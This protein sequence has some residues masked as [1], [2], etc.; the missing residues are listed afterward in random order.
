MQSYNKKKKKHRAK[1]LQRKEKGKRVDSGY[2]HRESGE[3]R[4]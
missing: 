4:P 2:Y 3:E 1:E